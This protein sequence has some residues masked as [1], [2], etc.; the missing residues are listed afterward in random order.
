MS[1]D[2]KTSPGGNLYVGPGLGVSL[3]GLITT[4][5]RPNATAAQLAEAPAEVVEA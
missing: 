3:L 2:R 5:S 1:D 4:L